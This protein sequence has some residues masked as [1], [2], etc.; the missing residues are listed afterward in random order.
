MNNL[1]F[2]KIEIA[3]LELKY[4]RSRLRAPESVLRLAES[5]ESR[6]QLVP[7]LAV[8][9]AEFGYV[10]VDGYLRVSALKRLCLDTADAWIWRD[11]ESDALLHGL[12]GAQGRHWDV[13]EQACLV[14]CLHVEHGVS[15]TR[16]AT[17]TGRNK[18]WVSRRLSLVESL[19]ED[20]VELVREGHVS[21]WC[22]LR[23]LPPLARANKAHAVALAGRLKSEGISTRELALFFDHFKKAAK[24]T[25]EN[26]VAEPR[27]FLKTLAAEE[28]RKQAEKWS[29]QLRRRGERTATRK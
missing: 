6:G 11:E 20:V 15:P 24:K 26:M 29:R 16:I 28:Q 7:V 19:S 9:T 13:Y 27:L 4:E 21:A 2:K 17:L 18:S 12:A 1:E 14:R 25:R 8:E 3:H 5:I 22:A 23:V 10:L